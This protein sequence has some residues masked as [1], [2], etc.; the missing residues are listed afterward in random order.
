[1]RDRRLHNPPDTVEYSLTYVICVRRSPARAGDCAAG[2]ARE[3]RHCAVRPFVIFAI[4][5]AVMD[6]RKRPRCGIEGHHEAAAITHCR[7]TCGAGDSGIIFGEDEATGDR[8]A[9]RGCSAL[10]G[11]EG[12][13]E[14][15]EGF[16]G[17]C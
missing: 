4:P 8:C 15:W 17:R 6:L 1:M 7:P 11:G 13:G 14:A 5:D 9:S 16:K 12:G 10:E 3:R 2:R